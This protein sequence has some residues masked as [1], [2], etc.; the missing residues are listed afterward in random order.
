MQCLKV[1]NYLKLIGQTFDAPLV[2]FSNE[3]E[4]NSLLKE[5]E[6]ATMSS[7]IIIFSPALNLT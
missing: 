6:E 3:T 2:S 5:E 1:L 7:I 4:N